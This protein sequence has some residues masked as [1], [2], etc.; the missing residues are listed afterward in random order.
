MNYKNI[1]DQLINKALSRNINSKLI[2]EKH[3]I[4]P[5]SIGGTN[6]LNNLV[7]LTLKEH[8]VAH[9]LLA[10]I[11]GGGLIYAANM[12]SNFKKYTS[13]N[14]VWLKIQF[15]QQLSELMSGE[16]H[17]NY[18]KKQSKETIEKRLAN[19]DRNLLRTNLGNTG[20]KHPN[21][22]KRFKRTNVTQEQIDI[23][24]KNL[25]GYVGK[26]LF[27]ADNPNYGKKHPGLNS[28]EKNSMYGKYGKDHPSYGRV[29]TEEQKMKIIYGR[30]KNKLDLYKYVVVLLKN[31]KS[32]KEIRKETNLSYEVIRDIHNKYQYVWE[33][34][35]GKNQ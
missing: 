34:I 12:M 31:D 17:P 10:K 5:R 35:E 9:L 27:G 14:Y 29:T 28:G 23:A 13:R 7:D 11:Y 3:H 26:Q 18:G 22:G 32:L 4:K 6:D 21:Y 19:T 15:R 16:N 30:I 8:F 2:T 25:D 24:M 33:H 1:Y 20:E